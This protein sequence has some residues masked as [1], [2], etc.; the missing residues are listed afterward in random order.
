MSLTW[1]KGGVYDG[2]E[3]GRWGP[4]EIKVGRGLIWKIIK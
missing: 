2:S 3:M 1:V 4:H